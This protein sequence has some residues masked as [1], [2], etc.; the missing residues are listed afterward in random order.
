MVNSEQK[1]SDKIV[2]VQEI[3]NMTIRQL[4]HQIIAQDDECKKILSA[5]R[6]IEQFLY[7][8]G[9]LSFGRDHTL[10]GEQVFSLQT[11]STACELTAGSII[12]CCESG[13]MADAY[14]LLR[15]YRDD[16]FFYLYIVV[17][18][19][20]YKLEHNQSMV[21][22]MENNIELWINN[23]LEN[24]HIGEILQ[25]IAEYPTVKTA[26][27]KYGLKTY[28]DKLGDRL[29]NYVHSNGIS[30]YNHNVRAYQGCSLQKQMQAL[31]KD[32]RFITVSFMFLL[33]QLIVPYP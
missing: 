2:F 16:L 32:M 24:L 10:C 26:I 18:D 14:S 20:C 5:M 29:N 17:Y 3:K 9:F 7:D 30:F 23:G 13:C 22:K 27:L 28:F 8:F 31:I 15:K 6:G 1:Q 12:S 33:A 11:I 21:C 19:A 4:N 25:T